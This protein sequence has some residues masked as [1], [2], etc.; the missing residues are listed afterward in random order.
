[1][2]TPESSLPTFAEIAEA[3]FLRDP[4]DGAFTEAYW[5]ELY[6]QFMDAVR[7]GDPRMWDISDK[8][9][10]VGKFLPLD[11][12]RNPDNPRHHHTGQQG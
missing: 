3:N 1:M 7:S 6:A 5:Q 11:D 10:T 8:M 4:T 9:R 2:S 12:D